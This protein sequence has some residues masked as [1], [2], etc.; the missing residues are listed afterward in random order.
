[1]P[2]EV[3]VGDTVNLKL[4]NGMTTTAEVDAVTDQDDINVHY[5][6]PHRVDLAN[7]TRATSLPAQPD[8]FW[9]MA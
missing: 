3:R 6:N 5:Y 1:M 4:A 2:R 7:A 8:E 9:D